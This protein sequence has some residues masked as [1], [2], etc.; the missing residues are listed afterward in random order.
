MIDSRETKKYLIRRV[1]A[2]LEIALLVLAFCLVGRAANVELFPQPGSKGR[3]WGLLTV[4]A[5][6]TVVIFIL[7]DCFKYGHLKLTDVLISQWI[8]ILIVNVITWLQLSLLANRILSPWIALQL[9]FVD[10]I[11]CM[12]T[13][14]VFTAIYHKLFVPHNIVMIYGGESA[15]DLKFKMDIRSDKYTITKLLRYTAEEEQ[16]KAAILSHDAVIINDVPARKRND[17]LKFCYENKVRTYVVPKIS[18][19]IL[20]EATDITLFDTPLLLVKGTG[21]TITQRAVKRAF[22]VVCC[23]LALVVLSPLFLIVALAIKLED[24]GPVFYKQQ[25]LTKDNKPFDILKF[26]SM[27]VGAE[28]NDKSIPAVDGDPRITKVGRIIR[29]SRIDELP[30]LINILKGEMSIVGPRP[31]RVEHVEKYSEEIPEFVLRTKVKGGLT[32]Y[33]QIYGKYNT[34]AYDKLRLD[35]IYIENYSFLMD[36]KLIL[37]TLRVM[38]K[39]ESTEGFDK[40]EELEKRRSFLLQQMEE[41]SEAAESREQSE[42]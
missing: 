1:E 31:E 36:I 10:A 4:Y 29:P 17:I 38:L 5:V 13:C 23:S 28:K 9:C 8:G 15:L 3:Y 20:K 34:S 30:Q 19:I 35:L 26:R 24:R 25:R 21:L 18:D 27:I 42:P 32:G 37:L 39:K 22:D 16:L 12:V 40:S 11:I 14:F 33:A 6:L 7:C 2:L 41:P